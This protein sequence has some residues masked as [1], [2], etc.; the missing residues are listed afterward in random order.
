MTC[1]LQLIATVV[2]GFIVACIAYRDFTTM[3]LS[4]T[5]PCVEKK[6]KITKLGNQDFGSVR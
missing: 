5:Y 2:V 3:L 1:R 6:W 4:L